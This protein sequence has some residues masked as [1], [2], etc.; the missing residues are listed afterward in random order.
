MYCPRCGMENRSE[1][2]YCRGCGLALPG[3]RLAMEGRLAPGVDLLKKD[4]DYLAGG[5]VTLFIFA[6]VALASF[7]FDSSKNWSVF[8]NLVLGLLISGPIIYRGLK[9]VEAA[10]KRVDPAH[11]A[12]IQTTAE[13][14]HLPAAAPAAAPDTDPL[15]VPSTPRSS[16]VSVPASVTEDETQPLRADNPPPAHR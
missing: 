14:A 3:V 8:V 11:T 6:L 5:V 10:I 9:R 2:K 1:Q 12:E 4:Y 15:A 7:F 16:P 13:P